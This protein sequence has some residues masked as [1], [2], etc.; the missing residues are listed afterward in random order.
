MRRL[1]ALEGA[2][3]VEPRR[4]RARRRVREQHHLVFAADSAHAS[5][6]GG[7]ERGRVA[8]ARPL[9]NDTTLSWGAV[10]RVTVNGAGRATSSI[11]TKVKHDDR[12]T[13]DPQPI[14]RSRS[15]EGRH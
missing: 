8:G 1:V 9:E 11:E 2:H 6:R 4:G 12:S 14:S 3:V 15:R 5:A 7:G 13:T 10:T